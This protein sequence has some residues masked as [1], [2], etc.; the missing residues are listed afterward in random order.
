MTRSLLLGLLLFAA[1]GPVTAAEPVVVLELFTSQGCSSCPPADRLLSTLAAESPGVLALSFHVDYWNR[2]GWPDPF[3][4]ARWTQRQRSYAAKLNQKNLYT[5]Q[6]VVNG[7]L[8]FP[9]HDE[10]RAREAT[11]TFLARPAAVSV[12]FEATREGDLVKVRYAATG[13]P[14]GSMVNLALVES[15]VAV[16]V[17]RGENAGR[18][19]HHHNVVRAFTTVKPPSG[20]VTLDVPPDTKASLGVVAYVQDAQKWH[21]LGASGAVLGK[22]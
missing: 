14:S 11:K 8:A 13:A 9:G 21:V 22:P 10:R 15:G 18:R 4:D 12:T 2:L 20:T 6:L 1:S 5:P 19:L 3:S 17:P 16:D 7:R